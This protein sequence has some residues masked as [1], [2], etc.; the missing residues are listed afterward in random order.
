MQYPPA[1]ALVNAVVKGRTQQ[2]AQR[3][4]DRDRARA[5]DRLARRS[6][7]SAPRRRRS[8][9]LKGEH[10]SQFFLKGAQRG[11]MRQALLAA[12]ARA[13]T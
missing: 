7:C 4:A 5:A 6:A 13:R 9:R 3:D 10:R 12:L 8:S 1:V 2:A 11:P